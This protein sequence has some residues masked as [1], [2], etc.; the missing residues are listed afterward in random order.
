MSDFET[1]W[2]GLA[3]KDMGTLEQLARAAYQAGREAQV[4]ELEEALRK[5]R[6]QWEE[7]ADWLSMIEDHANDPVY[8]SE[9]E[10]L[11]HI[12]E[13]CV[14]QNNKEESHWVG[15]LYEQLAEATEKLAVLTPQEGQEAA[16][17]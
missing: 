8:G 17:D 16:G 1:W 2:K 4:R 15:W 10:R 9:T 11:K 13:A 3:G 6:I 5:E 7:Y 12:A 14:E